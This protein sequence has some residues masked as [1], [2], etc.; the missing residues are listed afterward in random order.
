MASQLPRFCHLFPVKTF[1]LISVD[2][3]LAL[4][5]YVLLLWYTNVMY[6]GFWSWRNTK[7]HR[8]LQHIN[9]LKLLKTFLP[10]LLQTITCKNQ[11]IPMPCEDHG[12]QNPSPA[13]MKLSVIRMVVFVE[14]KWSDSWM[15]SCLKNTIKSINLPSRGLAPWGSYLGLVCLA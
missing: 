15:N 10:Q 6:T 14:D 8:T 2:G 11:E 5:I 3:N 4:L 7:W 12:Q 9:Y 1:H 13:L